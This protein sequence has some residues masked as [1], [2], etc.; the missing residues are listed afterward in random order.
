M[1]R[2][3][4]VLDRALLSQQDDAFGS[5]ARDESVEALLRSAGLGIETHRVRA[6]NRIEPR[7]HQAQLTAVGLEYALMR[8]RRLP[9]QGIVHEPQH[10][11]RGQQRQQREQ[12]EQPDAAVEPDPALRPYAGRSKRNRHL[13]R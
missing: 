2:A 7:P 9:C 4:R 5:L 6:P 3:S 13:D 1:S 10:T 8:R 11:G 12:D